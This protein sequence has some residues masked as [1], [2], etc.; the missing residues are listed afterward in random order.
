MLKLIGKE[1]AEFNENQRWATAEKKFR[2]YSMSARDKFIRLCLELLTAAVGISPLV[3]LYT[4]AQGGFSDVL[5]GFRQADGIT[6]Q[7]WQYGLLAM[8]TICIFAAMSSIRFIKETYLRWRVAHSFRLSELD[9]HLSQSIGPLNLKLNKMAWIVAIVMISFGGAVTALH[10]TAFTIHKGQLVTN[11]FAH[12]KVVPT[13]GGLKLLSSLEFQ[14]NC[15]SYSVGTLVRKLNTCPFGLSPEGMMDYLANSQVA[16]NTGMNEYGG[17]VFPDQQ[18]VPTITEIMNGTVNANATYSNVPLFDYSVNCSIEPNPTIN[19]TITRAVIVVQNGSARH[20]VPNIYY[21][22]ANDTELH[23]KFTFYSVAAWESSNVIGIVPFSYG[24][25]AT[26]VMPNKGQLEIADYTIKYLQHLTM[27]TSQLYWSPFFTYLGNKT[28]GEFSPEFL[29]MQIKSLLRKGHYLINTGFG[30]TKPIEGTISTNVNQ[31]NDIK[32]I[33]LVLIIQLL[34]HVISIIIALL[35]FCTP[36]I[37]AEVYSASTWWS[38]GAHAANKPVDGCTGIMS[39]E[40]HN[41]ILA[42]RETMEGHLQMTFPEDGNV[43]S[44]KRK[45]AG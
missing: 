33:R 43:P 45:Y 13:S 4:A 17:M 26:T 20:G 22:M 31:L 15:S 11:A 32:L 25:D 28:N 36:I 19:L 39:K 5:N 38:F 3:I 1:G 18:P 21:V 10:N 8:S 9:A 41:R 29:A 16:N 14:L 2:R 23:G 7:I 35:S 12:A 40:Q 30:S 6:L 42:L 37:A 24:N 44:E 27:V 34:I